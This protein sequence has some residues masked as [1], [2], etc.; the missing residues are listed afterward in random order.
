MLSLQSSQRDSG[1]SVR[2][3]AP[4][5]VSPA[6]LRSRVVTAPRPQ[7]PSSPPTSSSTS[8]HSFYR[9]NSSYGS[10]MRSLY[11]A[12]NGSINVNQSVSSNN[13]S[14]YSLAHNASS[15]QSSSSPVPRYRRHTSEPNRNYVLEDFLQYI[16]S[17]NESNYAPHADRYKFS[18]NLLQVS[19]K[20]SECFLLKNFSLFFSIRQ[21]SLLIDLINS[22]IKFIRDI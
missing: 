1:S 4:T 8:P 2:L 20:T 12:N 22:N 18:Q 16:G 9:Y 11:K 15:R 7:R 14:N 6:A 21:I 3:A 19:L 17:G 13:F 10:S 5:P